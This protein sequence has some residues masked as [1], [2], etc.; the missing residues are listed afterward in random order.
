MLTT[1]DALSR[2]T[3]DRWQDSREWEQWR[4]VFELKA[5]ERADGEECAQTHCAQLAHLVYE[6]GQE[7]DVAGEKIPLCPDHDDQDLAFEIYRR[8]LDETH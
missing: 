1:R 8:R 6:I 5:V 3:Y 2:D 4:T 7:R